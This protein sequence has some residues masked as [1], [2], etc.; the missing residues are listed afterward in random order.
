MS[1]QQISMDVA[2]VAVQLVR[3][4]TNLKVSIPAARRQVADAEV[5]LMNLEQNEAQRLELEEFID[6]LKDYS[7]DQ[8]EKD[9]DFAGRFLTEAAK[10]LKNEEK[11]KAEEVIESLEEIEE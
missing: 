7:F 10:M 5:A 8:F 2:E 1:N 6:S 11:K 9:R 4:F 3:I